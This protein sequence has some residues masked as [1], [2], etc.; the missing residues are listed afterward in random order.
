[1]RT[2]QNKNLMNYLVTRNQKKKTAANVT[3][4]HGKKNL[5]HTKKN[6]EVSTECQMFI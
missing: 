4:Q 5:K 3:K 6:I 2:R 1:M